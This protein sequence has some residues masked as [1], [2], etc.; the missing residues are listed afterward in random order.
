MSDVS[1]RYLA[2]HIAGGSVLAAA[3]A[4]IVLGP[5]VAQDS[6][7]YADAV[8]NITADGG[9]V[10]VA[11]ASVTVQGTASDIQAAG[12]SVVVRA[13]ATGD[14]QLAGAQVQF[15]GNVGDDLGVGGASLEVRGRIAGDA[16]MGGAVV[17]LNAVVG[18]NVRIG[19]A[20][21]TIGPG[22]DI[23]GDLKAGAANL[24]VSG[25]VGGDVKVAGGLVT[26]NA[27][28][29]G[30]VEVRAAQVVVNS[31]AR[32]SGDLVV[33]SL[34]EPVIAVG[35]VISG[36]VT[37]FEPPNW[38]SGTGWAWVLGF[39]LYIAAGTVLAGIVLMLFGGGV[40]AA[41]T[42]HVRHR[43]LSSFLFGILALIL[44]PFVGVVLM[45]TVIGITT[46][47]AILLI[48]PFLI[49]FG[50]TI[51]AAGIA[52]GILVRRRGDLG[53]A[54]GILMLIVGALVLVA[55]GLIPYVGPVLV[56]IAL[57]LGVGAFT[58][59]I[60]GRIRRADSVAMV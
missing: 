26:L 34:R 20:T 46:G 24:V 40:F 48:M 53:V 3:L 32:I 52:S 30:S 58:R 38:W 19:G 13:T 12:A 14:V 49:V 47:F 29:D 51:A 56:L 11:G 16:D 50:H 55:I 21:V 39:A 59:T 22:S 5:A 54:L 37:R 18:G 1:L 35:A 28:T 44:I 9:K 8:V 36:T 42:S 41:A 15:D 2:R 57:V 23:T 45:V 4:L 60:G 6:D 25:H 7:G 33:Y 31:A 43:P 10:K 27:S 17:M